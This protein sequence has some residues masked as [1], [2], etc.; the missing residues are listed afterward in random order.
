M[1]GGTEFG[2][3][4]HSTIASTMAS[5]KKIPWSHIFSLGALLTIL[6]LSFTISKKV[7][8]VAGL[9]GQQNT[10]NTSARIIVSSVSPSSSPQH[11]QRLDSEE[12]KHLY[13]KTIID[14]PSYTAD[15]LEKDVDRIRAGDF[16]VT[17][18]TTHVESILND[19]DLEG[20]EDGCKWKFYFTVEA[21]YSKPSNI[22]CMGMKRSRQVP[23]ACQIFK[24]IFFENNQHPFPSILPSNL[25]IAISTDD[26]N[27]V[28][29][30]GYKC[31]AS[32]STGG[33]FTITNFL[34]L[35]RMAD[36]TAYPVIDFSKRC[37]IPIWRGS[38][39]REPGT[40]DTHD[41][42]KILEQVAQKSS[43]I[44]TVLY[45]KDHPD[46]LDARISDSQNGMMKETRLWSKNATNGLNKAL[47]IHS[48]PSKEYY[49][50]YQ[51]ALVLCGKGAAFRTPIH[52]STGT[53]VVLQTCS[54]EEW[55][56][57]YM[58]PW[59]HYIPLDKD[60]KNL[61]ET[62]E[63]VR[64]HPVELQRIAKSGKWFYEE[65][66]S[67][68]RNY[69]HFYELFYRLAQLSFKRKIPFDPPMR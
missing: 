12:I 59:V 10:T 50:Q 57:V 9:R 31:F 49:T 53:V 64:D 56:Q 67:F 42:S 6:L 8:N 63:W 32:S 44:R 38:A 22:F 43:R 5:S 41:E 11:C 20:V 28:S 3:N 4:K 54:Y 30:E 17:K 24:S 51:T 1:S 58:V 45:S 60:L 29:K 69:D 68:Q 48:I 21:P 18:F 2:R 13:E 55:Y 23:W 27:D 34:E 33:R 15:I 62:L 65:Y 26:H 19:I 14:S 52:L 25:T 35:Q 39:W 16:P 7:I 66:L 46:L 36:R 61:T 37:K 40:I 47:P